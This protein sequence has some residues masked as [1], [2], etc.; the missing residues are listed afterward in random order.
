MKSHATKNPESGQASGA[1]KHSCKTAAE[2]TDIAYCLEAFRAY[3]HAGYRVSLVGELKADGHFH[4][5]RTEEDRHGGKPFRYC[6][7]LDFPQNIYFMDLKRG[8]SGL[9]FP[10]GQAPLSPAERDRLRREAEARRVERDRQ[11]RV[12]HESAA[13]R[14]RAT[15]RHRLPPPSD[16]GYLIRKGVGAHGLGFLPVWERRI[17]VEGQPGQFETI[18]IPNALLV[19]MRDETGAIHN[20]QAIFPAVCPVLGRDK[21]FLPRAR[22][23][24]LFHWIGQRTETVCLAEGYATAATI[25]ESTGYRVIVCFDAGN[26]VAVAPIIRARLPEARMVVCADNDLPDPRGRRAGLD[27]AQQAAARVDGFLAVP[28]IPGADFNDWAAALKGGEHG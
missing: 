18:Q 19:P 27:F 8:V 14:A 26:L 5:L 23:K 1:S 12:F 4:G 6:V 16:H 22:K 13:K 10:E 21:D 17:E 28:P 2:S 24:G 3:I 25:H 9:W 15:W 20:L 7:H 11:V